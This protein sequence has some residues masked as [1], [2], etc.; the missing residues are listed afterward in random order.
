MTT[1]R[2]RKKQIAE[3]SKAPRPPGVFTPRDLTPFD[4][5]QF[6]TKWKLRRIRKRLE[7]AETRG[8]EPTSV[9]P[10]MLVLADKSCSPEEIEKILDKRAAVLADEGSCRAYIAAELTLFC[11]SRNFSNFQRAK[12]IMR[13][14]KRAIQKQRANALREH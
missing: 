11:A 10:A 13:V 2:R 1:K 9:R 8:R 14:A 3:A 5:Q 4:M 6:S 12:M 7:E